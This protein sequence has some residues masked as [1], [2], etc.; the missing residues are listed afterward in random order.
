[1]KAITCYLLVSSLPTA[2]AQSCSHCYILLPSS[3]Q[4]TLPTQLHTFLGLPWVMPVSGI[5]GQPSDVVN[6][7][8]NHIGYH[9][10]RHWNMYCIGGGFCLRLWNIVGAPKNTIRRVKIWFNWNV[11]ENTFYPGI[12]QHPLIKSSVE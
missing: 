4:L 7:A 11:V 6:A 12:C 1:M 2:D 5:S 8:P 9:P 3:L 10:S